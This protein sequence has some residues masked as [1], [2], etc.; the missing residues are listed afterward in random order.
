MPQLK[1]GALNPTEVAP[2]WPLNSTMF[3]IHEPVRGQLEDDRKFKYN[4]LILQ[5][6]PDIIL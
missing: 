5:F 2:F 1:T 4:F 3:I 6:G